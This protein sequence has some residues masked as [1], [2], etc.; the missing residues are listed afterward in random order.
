MPQ[1]LRTGLFCKAKLYL[2]AIK[3]IR[4]IT[5]FLVIVSFSFSQ[6]PGGYSSG[7][8]F[9]IKSSAGTFSNAGTNACTNNT[10][11]QQWN[12]QS[13]N[14]YTASQ[15]TSNLRPTYFTNIANGNPAVRFAG[16][17]FVDVTSTVNIAGN[18]DY[19]G[20]FVV[21][22]TSSTAGGTTDGIGDYVLDRTTANS[23]LFDLK[24]VASGGTNR[25]FFRK[26]MMGLLILGG[27]PQPRLLTTQIFK[28]F[29]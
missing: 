19:C 29:I 18:T 11:L 6:S 14:A 27:Q 28:L 16:T 24:V 21:K 26:G 1:R 23:E 9:W 4:L 8:R 10:A 3:K 25:F 17:H 13:G 22:L 2:Y 15:A 20:F 5:F 12:D 7:L